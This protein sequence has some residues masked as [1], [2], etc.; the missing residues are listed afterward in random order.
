MRGLSATFARPRHPS[1]SVQPSEPLANAVPTRQR[2]GH[3]F[4]QLSQLLVLVRHKRS[5][6][7]STG[8]FSATLKC[9][10]VCTLR[11]DFLDTGSVK[12]VAWFHSPVAISRHP[13]TSVQIAWSM[14]RVRR[15]HGTARS[16]R[17]AGTFGSGRSQLEPPRDGL[18]PTRSSVATSHALVTAARHATDDGRKNIRR[19]PRAIPRTEQ[20]LQRHGRR[21][22]PD[23]LLR[24]E[25]PREPIRADM[26]RRRRQA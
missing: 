11:S 13:S 24:V 8:N 18:R 17:N 6:P 4:R 23:Y 25:P 16:T 5:N 3:Q 2:S 21:R 20:S 22:A 14:L 12:R 9:A 19:P 26:I 15:L 7:G 1:K 10:S